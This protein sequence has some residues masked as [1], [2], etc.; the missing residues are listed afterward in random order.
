MPSIFIGIKIGRLAG[1]NKGP[2]GYWSHLILRK[3]DGIRCLKF[4]CAVEQG[5]TRS[6]AGQ[7]AIKLAKLIATELN[8]PVKIW[9]G[10]WKDVK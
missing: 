3:A 10:D 5:A 6:F 1:G 4:A 8:V 2:D 9:V 7:E